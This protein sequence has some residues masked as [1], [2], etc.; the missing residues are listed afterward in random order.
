M[1]SVAS[2]LAVEV[3]TWIVTINDILTTIEYWYDFC[4]VRLITYEPISKASEK[5][6]LKILDTHIG[7]TLELNSEDKRI[8]Y[9]T[10][11]FIS[12]NND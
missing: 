3:E 8:C 10:D 11:R 2:M 9:L 6:A 4:Y 7:C 5:L 12:I 1:P